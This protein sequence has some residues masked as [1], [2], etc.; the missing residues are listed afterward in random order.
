MPSAGVAPAPLPTSPG[1]PA[2]SSSQPTPSTPARI[3]GHNLVITP[4]YGDGQATFRLAGHPATWYTLALSGRGAAAPAVAT[5]SVRTDPAGVATANVP[6]TLTGDRIGGILA[7]ISSTVAGEQRL[8]STSVWLWPDRTG[9]EVFGQSVTDAMLKAT[10]ND[11]AARAAAL[12]ELAAAPSSEV[13][14]TTT[15]P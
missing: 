15:K 8:T 1:K 11:P 10:E 4:G 6:V 9:A 2:A 5:I 13:S 12:A 14:M 3:S 7:D